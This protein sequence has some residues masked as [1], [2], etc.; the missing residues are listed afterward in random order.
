MRPLGHRA[1]AE[2]GHPAQNKALGNRSQP[3]SARREEPAEEP[4]LAQFLQPGLPGLG[5]NFRERRTNQPFG[6]CEPP[7]FAGILHLLGPTGESHSC[8]NKSL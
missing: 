2:V 8:A 7:N 5:A 3:L 4:S 6:G 1:A